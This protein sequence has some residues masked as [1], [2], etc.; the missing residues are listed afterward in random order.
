[1][2]DP[3]GGKFA[4]MENY[5]SLVKKQTPHPLRHMFGGFQ[6][7]QKL[8]PTELET[9]LKTMAALWEDMRKHTGPKGE[10][11]MIHVEFGHFSSLSS[12]ALFEKYAVSNADSLGMNEVEMTMLLD[13]WKGT[14]HDINQESDSEPPLDQVLVQIEE[15][16]AHAKRNG[17]RLSRVHTHPYG[18]FLI[19]Y[20]QSKW[21]S[22]ED[23]ILKSSIA[24][25]KYCLRDQGGN[26]PRDWA[27]H[28]ENFEVPEIP[29]V[30]HVGG[31]A[32][33]TNES[34]LTY[35][36]DLSDPSIHCWL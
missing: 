1:V 22:A 19:C 13:F 36:F 7:L 2:H 18:S 32:I 14:L 6:L 12:F 27:Q 5:H 8:D 3:N 25:P 4:Q 30:I 28:F 10:Q 34:T 29:K 20:D 9:R 35:D 33:Y 24:V 26:T 23:A 21:Q 15:L 31:E 16:F 11:H 17:Q